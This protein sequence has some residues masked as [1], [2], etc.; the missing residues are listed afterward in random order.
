[1][2]K[3]VS[4]GFVASFIL[5]LCGI[6]IL[7]FSLFSI[8]NYIYSYNSFSEVEGRVSG[9][10]YNENKE[11]NMTIQYIVNGKEYNVNSNL[12]EDEAKVDVVVIVKYDPKN[13]ERYIIGNEKMDFGRVAIGGIVTLI[14]VIGMIYTFPTKTEKNKK[15]E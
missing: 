9:Y 12:T 7:S 6:F 15:G 11:K 14:G 2:L 13:P 4:I 3:K 1:M 8:I 5:V 10:T